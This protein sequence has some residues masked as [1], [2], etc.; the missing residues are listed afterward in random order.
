[1]ARSSRAQ[2]PVGFLPAAQGSLILGVVL[3]RHMK[4][5][6]F[7]QAL[8]SVP[9]ASALA[10]QSGA[11]A[12]S[13]APPGRFTQSIP[14]LEINAPN[15]IGQPLPRFFTALQFAALRRLSDVLMPP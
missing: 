11:P 15:S 10:Q 6:R 3:S 2:T 4:R 9:A 14:K 5:R 1:M 13:S 7:F 12:A 8:A